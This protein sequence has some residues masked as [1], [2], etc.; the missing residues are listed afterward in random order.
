VLPIKTVCG[1]CVAKKMR[2]HNEM[3][4][5]FAMA[6]ERLP[7][8]VVLMFI[9]DVTFEWG[10]SSEGGPSLGSTRQGDT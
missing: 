1:G 8:G 5:A 6:A 3:S 2:A 4:P 10:N 7:N 9:S